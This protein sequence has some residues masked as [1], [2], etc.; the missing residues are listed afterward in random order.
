MKMD[1]RKNRKIAGTFHDGNN[2]SEGLG[3][4][5][6]MRFIRLKSVAVSHKF[7]ALVIVF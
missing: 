2:T 5:I 4:G 7:M 3:K 6:F 1:D